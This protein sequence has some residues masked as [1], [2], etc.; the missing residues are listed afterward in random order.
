MN[1]DIEK[2]H[3][4]C[5]KWFEAG[6]LEPWMEFACVEIHVVRHGPVAPKYWLAYNAGHTALAFLNGE[7]DPGHT[8]TIL[9]CARLIGIDLE[10]FRC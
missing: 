5:V 3:A 9:A 1:Y 2:I 6:V 7:Y 10:T 8:V 4:E